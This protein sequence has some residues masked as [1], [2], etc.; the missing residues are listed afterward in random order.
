MGIAKAKVFPEP[1]YA[2]PIRSYFFNVNGS[3]SR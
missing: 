2:R 3:D 1:V